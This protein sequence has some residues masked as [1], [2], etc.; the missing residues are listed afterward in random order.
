MRKTVK[1]ITT[2]LA[3]CLLAGSA[4]SCTSKKDGEPSSSGTAT[5][6][7]VT[8][9]SSA[10]TAAYKDGTHTAESDYNDQGYKTVVKVTVKDGKLTTVDCDEIDK[11]GGSKKALSESGEYG[12]KAGGA[13]AEWHEEVAAFEKAVVE[14]GVDAITIKDDGKTDAITGCTISV[15]HFVTVTKEALKKA[16]K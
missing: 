4:A 3:A 10:G 15:G 12:M 2:V 8:S 13:Q 14:K 1:I 5:T 7:A 16:S 9:A 6:S 11:D